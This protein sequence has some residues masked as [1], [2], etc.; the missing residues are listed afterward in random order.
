MFREILS[1]P[2]PGPLLVPIHRP[3]QR[4]I[5]QQRQ[6]K[7][8][9]ASARR[10]YPAVPPDGSDNICNGLHENNLTGYCFTKQYRPEVQGPSLSLNPATTKC[11]R[12]L[13]H[14]SCNQSLILR[15]LASYTIQ[16]VC[17]C[18]CLC[19]CSQR[20]STTQLHTNPNAG[21]V[22]HSQVSGKDFL[23]TGSFAG[24]A[25]ASTSSR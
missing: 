20:K 14:R 19:A 15:L 25:G 9:L 24:G 2:V 17:V 21:K 7:A 11:I 4:L 1:E 13:V 18:V 3:G 8:S 12:W 23:V 22:L 10:P 5:R 16:C 6:L